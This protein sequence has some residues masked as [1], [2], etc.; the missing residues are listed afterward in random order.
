MRVVRSSPR[1]AKPARWRSSARTV[2]ALEQ[3][4]IVSTLVSSLAA[5]VPHGPDGETE[6]DADF[7]EKVLRALHTYAV[8]CGRPLGG[9]ERET[10]GGWLDEQSRRAGGEEKVAEKWGVTGEEVREL[11]EGTA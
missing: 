8:G 7:E 5:P 1:R 6:G 9:K 2:A 3:T 4:G 10:P 11:R